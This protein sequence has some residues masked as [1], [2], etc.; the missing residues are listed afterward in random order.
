[1]PIVPNPSLNK[2]AQEVQIADKVND[3]KALIDADGG[4]SVHVTNLT[5]VSDQATESSI[6]ELI[7]EV[8]RL[9]QAIGTSLSIESTSGNGDLIA[10]TKNLRTRLSALLTSQVEIK[11]VLEEIRLISQTLS[12]EATL[13]DLSS[14]FARVLKAEPAAGEELRRDEKL[15]NTE[16]TGPYV[17]LKSDYHG[18]ARDNASTAEAVWDV[19]RFYRGADS[20][21]IR[22]RFRTNVAWDSRASGWEAVAPA[23]DGSNP[24]ANGYGDDY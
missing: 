8:I 6:Q 18:V 17:G 4:L 5:Q 11:Q 19:V 10:I 14:R 1:M 24:Y 16:T 22:F 23:P 20:K 13:S 21:I 7:N 2:L 3:R 9:E 12:T 15:A